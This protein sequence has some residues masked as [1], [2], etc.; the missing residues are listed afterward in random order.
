MIATARTA[1][2]TLLEVLIASALLA[3]MMA[4]L[5]AGMRIGADSWAQGE[6]LS[7]RA[8]R[9]LVVDNFFRSH[10]GN[11][12]PL[13]EKPGSGRQ[14]DQPPK[15]VFKGEAERLAFA[16]TLPPQVRGGLYKFYLYVDEDHERRDLKLAIR[17]FSSGGEAETA[18]AEPIED[19]LVA[20]NVESIRFGYQQKAETE[21]APPQWLDTWRSAYLPRLVRVELTLRGEAAWPPLL[22]ALPRADPSPDCQS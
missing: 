7:E 12:K 6:R 3:V 16:G 14:A 22:I 5:L 2:F 15:P 10:L 4:L 17:P 13:C 20:E 21:D 8:M 1:G 18:D 11:T 9:L 19:V